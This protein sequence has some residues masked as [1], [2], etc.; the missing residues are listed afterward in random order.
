MFRFV[1]E[2]S[3]SSLEEGHMNGFTQLPNVDV[4]L[5]TYLLTNVAE[6]STD[7]VRPLLVLQKVCHLPV[8]LTI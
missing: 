2:R 8:C 7:G 5:D 6:T 4:S 1:S 3:S